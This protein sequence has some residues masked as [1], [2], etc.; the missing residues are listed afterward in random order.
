MNV[1]III[2]SYNNKKYL[3]ALIRSLEITITKDCE[4]VIVDNNSNKVTR[5]YLEKYKKEQNKYRIILL[6]KNIG[7]SAGNNIGAKAAK[8]EHLV[9]LNNDM[10]VCHRWLQPLL[11]ELK[12]RNTG[13][14]GAKLLFPDKKIQ[15]AGLSTFFNMYPFSRKYRVPQEKDMEK[16]PVKVMAVTGACLGIRK[17][18]FH[19]VGGFDER[20]KLVF[21]DLDLCYKVLKKGKN[22]VYRPDAKL[23]HYESLSLNAVRKQ[24]TIDKDFAYLNKKWKSQFAKIIKA[25]GNRIKKELKD[26]KLIIYGTGIMAQILSKELKKHRVEVHAYMELNKKKSKKFGR[27]KLLSLKEVRSIKNSKILIASIFQHEIKEK[28]KK[29]HINIP[30]VDVMVQ[31]RDICKVFQRKI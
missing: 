1:S 23:Y 10:V 31:A 20:F 5:N 8:G 4:L 18:L 6:D 16:T 3:Q 30:V 11:K 15:H 14:V 22:V 7:Y 24:K 25:N 26:K 17:D 27:S 29:V 28:L 13:I 21:Q 19:K 9:F 2:L 12:K